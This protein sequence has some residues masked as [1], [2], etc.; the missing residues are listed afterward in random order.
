MTRKELLKLRR[1]SFLAIKA[2]FVLTLEEDTRNVDLL[3]QLSAAAAMHSAACKELDAS[4]ADE[5]PVSVRV[6]IIDAVI[7]LERASKGGPNVAAF[8]SNALVYLRKI[9]NL[10]DD[11]KL[12]LFEEEDGRAES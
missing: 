8:I 10:A 4:P 1:S 12:D 5:V 3:N 7:E 6:A 2:M 11:Q 9:I